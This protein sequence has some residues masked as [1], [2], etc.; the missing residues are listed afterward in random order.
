MA[1]GARPA[2]AKKGLASDL[3]HEATEPQQQRVVRA[4][5]RPNEDHGI[6]CQTLYRFVDPNGQLRPDSNNLLREDPES[7]FAASRN[8]EPLRERVG[9][10]Y[11][12]NAIAVFV[13]SPARA[14]G[15]TGPDAVRVGANGP[16]RAD[17]LR[18]WP[19]GGRLGRWGGALRPARENASRIRMP[20]EGRRA[21]AIG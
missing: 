2:G 15:C 21:L 11:L 16:A 8:G 13:V 5:V 10:F 6:T 7:F 9:S 12:P 19:D 1:L 4:H 17:V 18:C 20:Y 14:A 3:G